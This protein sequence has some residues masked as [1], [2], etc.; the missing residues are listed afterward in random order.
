[1]KKFCAVLLFIF[2]LATVHAQQNKLNLIVGT[3]NRTCE[4]KGMYVYEFDTNTGD[5]SLKNNTENVSNPSYLSVSK[6]NKFVYSVNQN[7]NGTNT[8]GVSSFNYNSKNGQ[9][10]LINRQDVNAEGPCY[11]IN[12]DKTVDRKSVV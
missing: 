6:D 4:S 2:A 11:I 5:F 8:S 1:M 12:D 10:D 9:L 7:A 3:Y